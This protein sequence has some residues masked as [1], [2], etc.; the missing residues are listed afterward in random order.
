MNRPTLIEGDPE[1][2]VAVE[3][4]VAVV[5]LRGDHDIATVDDLRDTIVRLQKRGNNVLVDLSH[6]TFVDCATIHVLEESCRLAER[7]GLT[8][9]VQSGRHPKVRQLLDLIDFPCH[10]TRDAAMAALASFHSLPRP[11]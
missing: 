6:A 7:L 10:D 3:D 4:R 2:R 1:I 5:L 9:A 11:A 8:F